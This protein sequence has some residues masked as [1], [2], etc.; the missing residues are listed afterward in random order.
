MNKLDR[1]A[2]LIACSAMGLIAADYL[3]AT[4]HLFAKTA[5]QAGLAQVKLG[6]LAMD[7]GS[8]PKVKGFGQRLIDD[9]KAIDRLKAIAAKDNILLPSSLAA[10][11]QMMLNRLSN[12]SG[13]AFDK[14]CMDSMVK[15]RDSE[16]SLF[17]YEANK[18]T[19][20]NLKSLASSILPALLTNRDR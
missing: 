7:K 14:A 16:I 2:F 19:N 10:K 12:L 3:S 9:H 6:Q 17:Q 4:D 20:N 11:D 1:I 18:G 8:S 15:T 13:A 5:A